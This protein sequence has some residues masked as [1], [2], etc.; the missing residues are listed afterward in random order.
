MGDPYVLARYA[1]GFGEFV[2]QM[3]KGSALD[4]ALILKGQ[5]TGPFTLGT[6][7]L[8]KHGR[9]AYYDNYFAT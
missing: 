7:L 9:C 1:A 6:N 8:D 5:G 2:A 3:S 4:T